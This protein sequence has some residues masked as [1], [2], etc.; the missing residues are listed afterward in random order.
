MLTYYIWTCASICLWSYNI[1]HFYFL[2]SVSPVPVF[3]LE[4][5]MTCDLWARPW[6]TIKQ[7]WSQ[8]RWHLVHVCTYSMLVH[9]HLVKVQAERKRCD[10][11]HKRALLQKTGNVLTSTRTHTL[12]QAKTAPQTNVGH[13]FHREKS[14]YQKDEPLSQISV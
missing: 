9:M 5:Q 4:I 8:G 11:G 14:G 10:G 7:Q 1:P 6:A 13:I 3:V 2:F 12:T